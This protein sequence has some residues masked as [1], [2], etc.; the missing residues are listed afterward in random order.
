[1][2]RILITTA[3]IAQHIRRGYAPPDGFKPVAEV[4]TLSE[5]GGI[6]AFACTGDGVDQCPED[7]E[8]GDTW[9]NF[10]DCVRAAVTHID[11]HEK[12]S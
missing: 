1:M 5:I 8:P 3:G 4:V 6:Y 12:R 2:P 11:N 9:S 7:L 10:E